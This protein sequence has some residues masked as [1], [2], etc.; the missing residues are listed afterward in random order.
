LNQSKIADKGCFA[1]GSLYFCIMQ[2]VLFLAMVFLLSACNLLKVVDRKQE[3]KFRREGMPLHVFYDGNIRRAIHFSDKDRKKVVLVHGY[4]AS[5]IGQYYRS[6]IELNKHCDVILPDL[7]YCGKSTG[8][9]VS[10]S[11]E[12]QVEHLR[13]LLDSIQ[14]NEPVY[15]IGNSY[16]GIVSAYFAEK[17]PRRVKRLVI[18]DSPVNDYTL[19][20]A[21]SLALAMEVPSLRELLAPTN[22]HENKKSLDIVFYDQPYIPRF[23][24]RQMVKYGSVP[25]RAT[26]LKMLD[27]LVDNEQT[28]NDH[29]YEWKMPVHL[30]WGEHDKL[31]PM[32]TCKSIMQRYNI[33]ASRLHVFPEAAH[34]VNVEHPDAFVDYVLRLIGED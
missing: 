7:L 6:A 1:R 21:D 29:E 30:C 3:K 32:S 15:L 17:Y 19:A 9:S 31:I 27:H 34:A 13:L 4:G 18:Y 22:I 28:Y 8:D 12:A 11:I 14:V 25:A 23:L 5:G 24:R 20:Y 10:F 2:R 16:G 33:P 26:Q